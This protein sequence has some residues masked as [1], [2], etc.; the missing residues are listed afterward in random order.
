[1]RDAGGELIL[2]DGDDVEVGT[3]GKLETHRRGLRHRAFSV[4]V[5]DGRGRLLLQRR[6]AGK[7][8]SAGLWANTCCGHPRPGEAVARAA[9][10]RL[11][12]EMGFDC[13]LRAVGRHAYRADVGGNLVEDEVVHLFVGRHDGAI[14]PNPDEVVEYV[15]LTPAELA[16]EVA[17]Q[18][19]RF[20]AWLLDYL[21]HLG[22]AIAAW[23]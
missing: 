9:R 15:W 16:A 10:R 21:E 11:G 12:E 19:H 14:A 5:K 1:M 18:R 3:C 20:S 6:A 4:F 22:D 23:N 13:E 17:G 8:H 7:Y 2:V